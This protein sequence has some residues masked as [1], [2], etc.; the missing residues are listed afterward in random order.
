MSDDRG[1]DQKV[2]LSIVGLAAAM[3]VFGVIWWVL[4]GKTEVATSAPPAAPITTATPMV[5]AVATDIGDNL[6]KSLGNL[7]IAFADSHLTIAGS[8]PTDRKKDRLLSQAK[9]IFGD[10]NVIDQLLVDANAALPNWKGKTLDLMAKLRTL[11]PF[12][13]QLKGDAIDVQT[14]V[15]DE[16][17]KSALI[18]WLKDF[19]TD[20]SLPVADSGINV[21]AASTSS[22]IDANSLFNISVNFASG[23]AEIPADDL[24]KLQQIAAILRE[25]GRRI[26][27]VGHTD[28]VGD[29]SANVLL[30]LQRANSVKAFLMSQS[31]D[32]NSIETKG[33]GQELPIADN[34]TAEG[35]AQN[36]RIEFANAVTANEA[37]SAH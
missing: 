30:S 19:F 13:L 9:L 25:D 7:A 16:A 32:I 2:A 34:A 24:N 10:A 37:A 14:T 28:N 11:G 27:I 23:S 17:S 8:V 35:R 29:A 4:S 22:T 18:T 26:L 31:I 21:N 3:V 1:T 12:A 6:P 5:T 36:R 33:V 15:K 20:V